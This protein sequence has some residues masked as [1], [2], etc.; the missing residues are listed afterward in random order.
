MGIVQTLHHL[1]VNRPV[2]HR[3]CQI[4]QRLARSVLCSCHATSILLTHSR[5]LSQNVLTTLKRPSLHPVP[6][7]GNACASVLISPLTSPCPRPHPP[8]HVCSALMTCKRSFLRPVAPVPCAKAHASLRLSCSPAS[9]CT[10]T[11]CMVAHGSNRQD[12]SRCTTPRCLTGDRTTII[13]SP[14]L[15]LLAISHWTCH[16]TALTIPTLSP[17]HT[18]ASITMPDA[19]TPTGHCTTI[20][21]SL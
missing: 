1:R 5:M 14:L 15:L 8:T 20:I 2:N 7:R 11:H 19:E 10:C 9:V 18:C 16:S 6:P 4:Q 13:S 21:S 12:L 3:G 17:P